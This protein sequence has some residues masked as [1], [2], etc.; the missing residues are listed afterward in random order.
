MKLKQI[1]PIYFNAIKLKVKIKTNINKHKINSVEFNNFL[2]NVN[3]LNTIINNITCKKYAPK[4]IPDV[5]NKQNR[6]TS[7]LVKKV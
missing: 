6:I 3:L 7:Q 2:S 5:I 4:S 1:N